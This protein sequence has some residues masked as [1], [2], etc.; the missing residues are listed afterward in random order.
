MSFIV[1]IYL[2]DILAN[3]FVFGIQKS[4]YMNWCLI[5]SR[6]TSSENL[7]LVY[8]ETPD[9]TEVDPNNTSSLSVFNCQKLWEDEIKFSIAIFIT[10]TICYVSEFSV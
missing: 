3:V 10:M 2:L 7:W 8:H 4:Q 6:N 5:N 1:P 9:S